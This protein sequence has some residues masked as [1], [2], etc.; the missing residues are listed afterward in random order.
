MFSEPLSS[1]AQAAYAQ[2]LDAARHEELSRSIENL[3]GSFNRKT[4]RGASYWYYQYTDVSTSRVRQLFVGPDSDPKVREL[5]QRARRRDRGEVER[6]AKAAIALGCSSTTPVHFRIIRRLNEVGFFR[7]GGVLVGTHA[8]LTY[9]NA[10]G[11]S[12]GD[13]ARTQDLDFAHAG[14][15]IELA[16]PGSLKVETKS[17]VESLEAGF[18]PTPGFRPWEKTATF[19]S[20]SDKALKIDFLTPLVGRNEEVFEHE[21]LGVNLQPLRFMEFILEDVSQAAV[22]SA[23]GAC[24]VTVPDP[25]RFAL[26]KILVHVERRQ[27]SPEKAAK[28][29][30][31]AAALI[32][33]I[34]ADQMDRLEALWTGIYQRG[35]G[36]RERARKGALALRK[37]AP[38]LPAIEMMSAVHASSTQPPQRKPAR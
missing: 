2:L 20:K 26:H 36:W 16:L 31:Q 7:A 22:I 6:M 29:L 33:V 27:G 34:G 11:V 10:L 37:L 23:V 1:S 25:A 14:N 17:V 18:L 32:E 15:H 30:A 4:V 21:Q 12:W 24:V 3:S 8:F 13:L 38:G 28:D 35:P 19:V 9:G 5:E